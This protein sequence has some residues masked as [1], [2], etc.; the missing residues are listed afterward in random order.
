VVALRDVALGLTHHGT[1]PGRMIQAG[2]P[3]NTMFWDRE[4]IEVF[5]RNRHALTYRHWIREGLCRTD[6]RFD[7]QQA[8]N[9]ATSNAKDIHFNLDGMDLRQ[10]WRVGQ[11]SDPYAAGITSWEFVQVL[12]DASLRDR[13]TFWQN[14]RPVPLLRVLHREGVTLTP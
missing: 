8:F 7:F 6:F 12:R 2:F 5:G 4:A 14:G 1:P 11:N 9:E 13:T 10:A 3:P